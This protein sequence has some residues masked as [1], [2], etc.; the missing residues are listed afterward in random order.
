MQPRIRSYFT[1]HFHDHELMLTTVHKHGWKPMSLGAPVLCCFALASFI[2]AAIIEILADQ[3]QRNGGLALSASADSFSTFVRFCYLFLPTIVAVIYSLLW[4]WI[5]LDVKRIQPWLEMSR[6]AGATAESSIFLDYPYDF[7]AF[8]PIKA[9]RRRHWAVFY[10]GTIMVIIFWVVTPLQSAVFG[11]GSVNVQ[12]TVNMSPVATLRPASEQGPMMDTSI[13]N[14]GYAQTWL[15]QPNPPFATSEYTLLPFTAE[16]KATQ[17]SS[18]NWTAPTTKYWTELQCWPAQASVSGPASRQTYDFL[19]GR[20]CNASEIIVYGNYLN[21]QP[22]RM[23]YIG[24]HNSPWADYWLGMTCSKAS[25]G[26]QFLATWGQSS[27]KGTEYKVNLTSIFCEPNYYKQSV[28]ATVRSTDLVPV[29]DSVVP[30]GPRERV[31]ET[32]FNR[33]AFEHLLGAGVSAVELQVTREYP[34]GRLLEHH[35]QV[36][37]LNMTWPMSPMAGFAVGSQKNLTSLDVFRDETV[38]GEAYNATHKM[39]FNLAM[40][41]ALTNVTEAATSTGTEDFFLHGIIVSRLFSAIV[42]GFM[43]LVGIFTV[44]LWWHV[45]RAPSR[46]TMDPA[47]LGSLI[48]MCQNSPELLDRLSG[49]GCVSEA[50]LKDLFQD[51]R[52][53]L[54]CGCQSSSRQML[55]KVVDVREKSSEDQRFSLSNP[56]T[57]LSIGHYSPVKPLALRREVGV[58]VILAM[59]G[60]V[61]G[62]IYLKWLEHDNKGIIRPNASFE[63]LQILENYV[64]TVFA[65]LL[66]P[67]WVLVNRL[68]CILQPFRDLW[69]GGR[70]AKGSIS[71]RYTS[72][73]PQLVFWRAARSG[74]FILTAMCALALLSNL[75]AVGLGGLFNEKP[76][77]LDYP[78][79]FQQEMVPRLNNHSLSTFSR[80]QHG[81]YEVPFYV[82][83]NNVSQGTPLSPWVTHDYFYQPFTVPPGSGVGGSTYTAQTRGFGADPSCSDLGTFKTKGNGPQLNYTMSRKG[84]TLEGCKPGFLTDNLDLNRTF[85]QDLTG[86]AA[87]ELVEGLNPTSALS[88]C[89]VPLMLAWSRTSD[90]TKMEESEM[91]TSVVVCEPVFTTA[92]F[93]VTV[94]PDGYVISSSQV[95][96]SS[97]TLDYPL[98]TNHTDMVFGL[99]NNLLFNTAHRWHNDSLSKDWINYLLKIQ[100]GHADLLDPTVAPNNTALIPSLEAVYRETF[101]LFLGVNQRMFEKYPSPVVVSGIRRTVETRIF[102]DSTALAISLVVLAVNI[103]VAVALYGLA[104]KHF[105]PRMPTTIASILAYLAPSRAVREYAGPGSLGNA[106]FSFGRYVGE[107]GRANVGIE[108]DPYVVP[109]KLSAL[110]KGDTEPRTGLLRRVLGRRNSGRGDDTWL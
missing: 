41:R 94:D 88:V 97:P 17:V 82:T 103:A 61:A 34:F 36:Q 59:A 102:M 6:P 38:L 25:A 15:N 76:I 83:M 32:E 3:S 79:V 26:N 51:Q 58:M 80:N 21:T 49:K 73:P 11:T 14:E 40:R 89:G 52:F 28:N 37:H 39:L 77:A 29:E 44:L 70:P 60:A 87:C 45:Y 35:S 98:S 96:E 72:L 108:L 46:L 64:P 16:S 86:P 30:L 100:P 9:A 42:E 62:L 13:L 67:F 33:T 2:I 53:K 23:L 24:Y 18:T 22:Y 90:A 8:V 78:F 63:V 105:L 75:L 84:E 91:E 55:I 99:I 106:T 48:S 50:A 47:S 19:N 54:F 66:E 7:I 4:S 107:D 20:G 95:S 1:Q 92:M 27:I 56:D 31:A 109:V 68:L 65:T 85:Y 5:D 93:D 101:A 110:R 74:H 69:T 12:R 104:I 71:A 81:P 57:G 43:I 10:G